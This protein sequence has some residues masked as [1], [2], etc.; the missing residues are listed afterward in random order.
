MLKK[1]DYFDYFN[2]LFQFN[3]IYSV[4]IINFNADDVDYYYYYFPQFI[5]IIVNED[6]NEN[7]LSKY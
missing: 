7:F 6:F 1:F 3:F 4:F 2:L 5:V